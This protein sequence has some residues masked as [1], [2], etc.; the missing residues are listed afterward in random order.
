MK[1]G[2]T[3]IELLVVIAII[4]ILASILLPALSRARA[5]ARST[6]CLGHLSQLGLGMANYAS[7]NRETLPNLLRS[8]G[9]STPKFNSWTQLLGAY[10]GYP[11]RDLDGTNN[12]GIDGDAPILR[13]PSDTAP[14]FKDQPSNHYLGGTGGMTYIGNE[15]LLGSYPKLNKTAVPTKMIL[16][17]EGSGAYLNGQMGYHTAIG[18]RHS[19]GVAPALINDTQAPPASIPAIGVNVAFMDG[20]VKG[21]RNRM[22]TFKKNGPGGGHW[23]P[24]YNRIGG[25]MFV[26]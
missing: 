17:T 7:D 22:I 5:T 4:A 8:K 12:L 9:G 18:Y 26:W 14:M 23:H 10:V 3:L 15:H 1:K 6:K 21:M 13:C 11:V 19:S 16:L 2:F 25:T 20:H 24:V